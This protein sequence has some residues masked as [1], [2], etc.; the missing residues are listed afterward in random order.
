MCEFDD[1]TIRVIID[2]SRRKVLRNQSRTG[3]HPTPKSYITSQQC[4]TAS[5]RQLREYTGLRV[6]LLCL[7]RME[8]RKQTPPMRNSWAADVLWFSGNQYQEHHS[9]CNVR[10]THVSSTAR[11]VSRGTQQHCCCSQQAISQNG[12]QQPHYC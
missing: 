6:L 4:V 8:G 12:N 7:C 3:N 2:G 5:R 9:A 1:L 10:E 11:H